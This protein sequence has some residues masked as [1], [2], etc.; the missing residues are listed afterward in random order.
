M[1]HITGGGLTGEP[2]AGPARRIPWRL[3][4]AGSWTWPECFQW[5]QQAGNVAESEM[6]RTFNCGV[7]MICCVAA[8]DADNAIEFLSQAGER[9]WRLGQIESGKGEAHVRFD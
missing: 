9:V 7:G 2:A 4:T 1:A 6:Y 5:L 3:S 8:E